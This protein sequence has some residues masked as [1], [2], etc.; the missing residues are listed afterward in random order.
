MCVNTKSGAY[1]E[2]D[3]WWGPSGGRVWEGGGGGGGGGG[4]FHPPA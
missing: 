1:A 4:G 2:I 3:C